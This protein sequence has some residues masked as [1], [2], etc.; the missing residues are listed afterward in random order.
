MN[1]DIYE[2]ESNLVF[3]PKTFGFHRR[4]KRAVGLPDLCPSIP[5]PCQHVVGAASQIL[6]QASELAV[7]ID[8][9][10][11]KAA[12]MVSF[13]EDETKQKLKKL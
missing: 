1:L 12:G 4:P 13:I 8:F 6:K 7:I 9:A 5:N 3:D 2:Q 11:K 10:A